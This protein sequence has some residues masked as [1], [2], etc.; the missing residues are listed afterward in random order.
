MRCRARLLAAAAVL[1]A[2][3]VAVAAQRSENHLGAVASATIAHSNNPFSQANGNGGTT[4]SP[5]VILDLT[6][7]FQH[8][9]QRSIL[10]IS[11]DVNLQRYFRNY[12]SNPSY[13]AAADYRLRAAER[14]TTHVR[15]DLS[16]A[17]L[18]SFNGFVPQVATGTLDRTT[19]IIATTPSTTAPGTAA[20]AGALPLDPTLLAP[21]TP[22]LT[23]VGLYGFR[24]RRRT[25]RLSADAAIGVSERDNLTVSGYAELTRYGDGGAGGFLLGD[26]DA[27]S[28]TLGYQRRVSAYINLG[29]QGS[30]SVFNY[31]DS[32]TTHVYA[33]E[34]TASG[35][36]SAIWTLTGAFGV[37]FVDG[38]GVAGST[39]R[40][41][42]S[43]SVNLCRQGERSTLC[44]QASREV[45]PSGVSGSQYVTTAGVNWSRRLSER[46]RLS[47]NASY[48]DVGGDRLL[49]AP[50]GVPLQTQYGQ[51][52][53]GYD[54][55]LRQR[56]R[57]VA[58]ANARQ[59]FGGSG[60]GGTSRPID[61]GGQVGLSY[62][63]GD[64][65]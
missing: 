12:G 43:G 39:R 59:L 18:G 55:Q 64:I 4:S 21:S 7:T 65:R 3:P 58:S 20:N 50:G 47:L 9:T 54:R 38:G 2:V 1:G 46:D 23:D 26:Y 13:S 63:F 35:R 14:L 30:A 49:L 15:L 53:L 8:L 48:S 37:S 42:P 28:G 36:L 44:A 52:T 60:V 51:A 34:A 10:S 19:G 57:L 27:Y 62:Q 32:G 40:T 24:N 22:L 17:V 41:S 6:P 33:V 31:R 29:V 16:S 45:S 11:G 5:L 61:V 56:L 25:G